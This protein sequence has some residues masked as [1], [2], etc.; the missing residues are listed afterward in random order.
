MGLLFTISLSACSSQTD[1]DG[2]KAETASDRGTVTSKPTAADTESESQ[3]SQR[4]IN[5]LTFEEV[6]RQYPDK[7]VLV[8]VIEETGYERN[9]PFRT[10]EVNEYLDSQGKDFAV[11]FY[12]IRALITDERTDFYTTYVN[13]MVKE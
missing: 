10:R 8:W 12:P 1:E 4:D 7:T 5:F 11:C 3:F 6:Q 9:Y 2:Q 13:D